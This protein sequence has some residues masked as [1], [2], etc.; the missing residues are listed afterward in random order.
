VKVPTIIYNKVLLLKNIRPKFVIKCKYKK[1]FVRFYL[2]R[3]KFASGWEW[4]VR[5]RQTHK[6]QL[7]KPGE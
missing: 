4:L 7:P 6:H 2:A 5:I 3:Q 1:N